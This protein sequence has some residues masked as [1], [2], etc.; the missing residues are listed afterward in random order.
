M[1]ALPIPGSSIEILAASEGMELALAEQGRST[2]AERG[3]Q[4]PLLPTRPRILVAEDDDGVAETRK[5][6][7]ED[8]GYEIRRARD[9]V[10]AV[11]LLG[12]VPFDLVLLDL[13]MP[14]MDGFDVC[15]AVRSDKRLDTLPILVLTVHSDPRDIMAGFEAGVTDYRSEEHTSE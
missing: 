2:I 6:V 1:F 13:E 9:G 14:G 5:S 10:A 3:P 12:A 4:A 15:R 11:N 8:D 7:L